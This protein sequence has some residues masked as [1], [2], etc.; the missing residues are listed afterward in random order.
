MIFAVVAMT[1]FLISIVAIIAISIFVLV[2]AT[3]VCWVAVIAV[4][5]IAYLWCQ[6]S[7]L[8][9]GTRKMI[10]L[11]RKCLCHGLDNPCVS[12]TGSKASNSMPYDPT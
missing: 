4:Y 2:L 5:C 9:F 1:K 8:A 6:A 11:R 12:K 10:W 3:G 7:D